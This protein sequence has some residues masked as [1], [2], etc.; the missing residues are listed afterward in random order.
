MPY[1]GRVRDQPRPGVLETVTDGLRSLSVPA[2]VLLAAT[3]L[4]AAVLP[5]VLHEFT[6]HNTVHHQPLT[7][8]VLIVFSV[9]NVEIGRALAGGLEHTNQPH[10]ALSGWACASALL[11]PG[12][13]LL[14]VVPATYAHARWRGLRVPLTKWVG[15]AAFLVLSGVAAGVVAHGIF[16]ESSHWTFED[17]GRGLIAVAAAAGTFLLVESA[18]FAAI[19]WLNHPAEEVWLRRT[20]RDKGFYL[21]ETGVLLMGGLLSAVW[22]GGAWFVILFLPIYILAQRAVLDEPLRERVVA[23]ARLAAANDDLRR[24]NAFKSDLLGML[25]HELGNPLTSV[26]G[27][28][29]VATEELDAED[30]AAARQSLQVVERNADRMRG[31]LYELLTHAASDTTA[32]IADQEECV[33]QPHLVAAAGAFPHGQRPQVDCPPSLTAWVQP[34]HLDQML[35]NLVSNAQKYAGGAV[36]IAAAPI[37]G[38]LHIC[39]S[40]DGPGVPERF[41]ERLFDR[42]TRDSET[43]RGAPGAGL[44]LFITRQLARANG[45]DVA[46]HAAAPTGSA[47]TLALP[48]VEP[49]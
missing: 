18:L 28:A 7:A 39:V 11:L 41:R 5:F 24:A 17:G 8:A 35:L 36:R 34:G 49:R 27:Y 15:S 3:V 2:R 20:L 12:P 45:G 47:F 21:T 16:G 23:A 13:W 31:V 30:Y 42:Y 46:Y 19:A 9:V 6:V 38:M 40:D 4:G 10:K 43:A 37:D 48:R 44:G 33:L 22:V 1:L 14:L 32:L 26:T 25:G 29:Q